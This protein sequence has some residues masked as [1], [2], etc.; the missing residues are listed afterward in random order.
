MTCG[1][2]QGWPSVGCCCITAQ[3]DYKRRFHESSAACYYEKMSQLNLI[4]LMRCKLEA[5]G[6]G[7]PPPRHVL[8]VSPSGESATDV[9]P[10]TIFLI[11]QYWRIRKKT[12]S[13]SRRW[14]GSQ[15]KFNHYL[16]IGPLPTFPRNFIQIHS[17][18]FFCAKLLTDKQ[19][20]KHIL[21]GGGN[22]YIRKL[23][24]YAFD[25]RHL[26]NAVINL[27]DFWHTST[28]FCPEHVYYINICFWF[29]T[30]GGT[31]DSVSRSCTLPSHLA[32]YEMKPQGPWYHL[33]TAIYRLLV[34][35][36]EQLVQCVC[37]GPDN[38]VWTK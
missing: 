30:Q 11:F 18:V 17:E 22:G 14:S 23:G 9:C 38:N 4:K 2:S 7:I 24:H 6:Q 32:L 35:Q 33:H 21:L 10:L 8:P 12:I 20:W 16:F 36:V 13:V 26:W 27:H 1:P 5:L 29:I 28:P 37:V 31:T 34:V 15:P 25:C 19:R 3:A